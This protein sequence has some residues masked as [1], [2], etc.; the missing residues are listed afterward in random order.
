MT[1]PL[2]GLRVLDLTQ[3]LSGPQATL[4]LGG[5]GAEVIRVDNPAGDPVTRTPPFAGPKGVSLRR[6]TEEDLSV[7]YLKRARNKKAITLNLKEEKGREILFSLAEKSDILVENFSVGVT[8]RLGIDYAA[9]RARCPNVIYCSVTVYGQTGPD[10]HLK[11]YDTI[12]QAAS[13]LMNLTGFPG[14]PPVKAGSA[15]ADSIGGVF[16]FSGIMTALYHRERTGEG[17]H[18]D[19]SMTDCLFSLIFDEPLDCYE[20]MGLPPRMGNRIMRISPFNAYPARDG[21]LVIATGTNAHWHILARTIGRPDLIEKKEY[22]NIEDRLP[23]NEEIDGIITGWT[24][25]RSV[26]EAIRLLQAE[27]V[28]CS[29]VRTIEDIK[30]W[31]HLRERGMLTDLLHPTAGKVP[32]AL[33]Q[34]FPIRFS[35]SP[36]AYESPAPTVG[37]HN[38]EIYRDVLGF[39]PEDI[40]RLKEEGIA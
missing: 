27:G 11:G 15:L 38:D 18:V 17:Q 4:F 19:I 7:F 21:W 33:A 9:V 39:G 24:R 14:G 6:Q 13:G 5:L 25:E 2:E 23:H 37:Q 36:G 1:K 8:E 20:E 29:P 12:T 40:A 31:P 22:A 30:N 34:G 3:Y 26:E 35:K 32:G 10:A 16:A 28:I